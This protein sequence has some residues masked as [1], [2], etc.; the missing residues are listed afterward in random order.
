MGT[1]GLENVPVPVVGADIAKE[2]EFSDE[3]SEATW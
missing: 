1:H 2:V 3:V